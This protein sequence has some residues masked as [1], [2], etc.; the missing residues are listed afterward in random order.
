MAGTSIVEAGRGIKTPSQGSTAGDLGSVVTGVLAGI[1]QRRR[2]NQAKA[3]EEAKI[4]VQRQMAD[5]QAAQADAYGRQVDNAAADADRRF[6]LDSAADAR[7]EELHGLQVRKA[8]AEV[9]QMESIQESISNN[10][11]VHRQALRRAALNDSTLPFS[12]SDV[13]LMDDLK[14]A[15]TYSNY[16]DLKQGQVNNSGATSGAMANAARAIYEGAL[17][18]R[19]Q[20]MADLQGA[21]ANRAAVYQQVTAGGFWASDGEDGIV[22]LQFSPEWSPA[23]QA[24]IAAE[25][26]AVAE[27]DRQVALARTAFARAEQD[28]EQAGIVQRETINNIA[29]SL[30]VAVSNLPEDTRPKQVPLEELDQLYVSFQNEP[31]FFQTQ[32][33]TLAQRI[34]S[35]PEQFMAHAGIDQAEMDRAMGLEAA[36]QQQG[37][38]DAGMEWGG[39]YS[40]QRRAFM[41]MKE[42]LQRGKGASSVLLEH[43][44]TLRNSGMSLEEFQESMIPSA[45][46][47]P[48]N[49]MLKFIID[50]WPNRI[51]GGR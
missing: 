6:G 32:M 42:M 3:L 24:Q 37:I 15:E 4:D 45:G 39:M 18:R 14:L 2:E 47:D 13:D 44:R 34:P 16:W 26:A 35:A 49:R 25:S 43:A 51:G 8:A 46:V 27:A 28:T 20:A 31:G 7:A 17:E 12:A 33:R 19:R 10:A 38:I 22:Q 29:A 48:D 1:D 11:A 41:E 21:L 30:G 5:A 40:P 9:S 23:Q 50:S 36:G